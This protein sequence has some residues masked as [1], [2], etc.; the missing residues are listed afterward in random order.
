MASP[1]NRSRR[2]LQPRWL[3]RTLQVFLLALA[4]ATAHWA[5][6]SA[7]QFDF[8]HGTHYESARQIL[9]SRLTPWTAQGLQAESDREAPWTKYT[10]FGKGFYTHVPGQFDLA[11]EWAIRKTV[12]EKCGS[13]QREARWGV[14]VFRVHPE[15]LRPIDVGAPHRALYFGGKLHRPWNAPWSGREPGLRQTWLEFVEVNRHREE[16][17]QAHIQQPGDY[18][19]SEYYAWIQGPIWVPKDSGIDAGGDPIPESIHQRNW[20]REGLDRV[21]NHPATQ[22]WIVDGTVACPASEQRGYGV[23]LARNDVLVGIQEELEAIPSCR[24]GGWGIDCQKTVGDVAELRLIAGP[25][26]TREEAVHWFCSNIAPGSH[27]RPPLARFLQGARFRFDG[28]NHIISNG[29]SCP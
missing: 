10:D 5:P 3:G 1:K 28:E 12:K 13:G 11:R 2:R 19:W 15:L 14:V 18:D 22:R 8:F 6:A 17:G 4:L 21:L 23:F 16:W 24:L 9:E 29:P 27:Y 7:Q 26:A 20:L 25:F